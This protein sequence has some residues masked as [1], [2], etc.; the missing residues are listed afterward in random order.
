LQQEL[1]L[2]T[3][4]IQEL[5]GFTAEVY[6]IFKEELIPVLLKLFH[7]IEREETL[8]NSVYKANITLIQ[9]MDTI[10]KK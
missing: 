1:S 8:P 6:Q 3:R 7:K 5:D 2:P 10:T 9:D 4:K